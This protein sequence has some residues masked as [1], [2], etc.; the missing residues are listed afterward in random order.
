[1][2]MYCIVCT[3]MVS[4]CYQWIPLTFKGFFVPGFPKLLRFQEHHDRILKKLLSR[5]FKNLVSS[6]LRLHAE[7]EMT[8]SH[9]TLSDQIWNKLWSG[10][11]H[12]MIGHNDPNI[13]PTRFDLFLWSYFPSILK[14]QNCN[15]Y[16][17]PCTYISSLA[18]KNPGL[19]AI[20]V[21]TFLCGDHQ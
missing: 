8:V 17:H 5:L 19:V 15:C 10:Q 7:L 3:F 13:S 4:N 12:I 11:F 20:K 14:G 16:G 6:I 21:I 9:Q 2:Y 1:M 18:T